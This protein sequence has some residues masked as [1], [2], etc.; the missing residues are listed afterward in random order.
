MTEKKREIMVVSFG[1]THRETGE[2]NIGAIEEDLKSAFPGAVFCRAFTAKMV[3]RKLKER[4]GITVLHPEE[5]L[6]K[7]AADGMDSVVIQPTHLMDGVEY[8]DI[9]DAVEKFRRE[10]PIIALGAPLLGESRDFEELI[11]AITDRTREYTDG[12]T[13][14]C[15]M[16]HGTDAASNRVYT[17]L[18]HVLADR[19][20]EDYF[21]GTVE[22]EPTFEDIVEAVA[23]AGKYDKVVLLPLMVVAGDHAV[24]DMAGDGEESWKSMFERKGLK[25]NCIL[26]GLG[27]Y[28]GVRAIYVRHAKEAAAKIGWA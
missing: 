10:F 11:E 7:A 12:R 15:F 17:V 8:H 27:E 18:Q 21:I 25:V 22:A 5:A 13:A 24:N 23:S 9:V 2:K 1:T 16:G 26:E 14:V 28:P 6:K 4:D 20:Y 19:G 3:I